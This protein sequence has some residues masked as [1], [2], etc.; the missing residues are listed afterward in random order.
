MHVHV[1]GRSGAG[2]G[3]VSGRSIPT[4]DYPEGVN[5]S[6]QMYLRLYRGSN[7][8]WEL[9]PLSSVRCI[10]GG[11]SAACKSGT[12]SHCDL[13]RPIWLSPHMFSV[14]TSAMDSVEAAFACLWLLEPA[15]R[16]GIRMRVGGDRGRG[17]CRIASG[18]LLEPNWLSMVAVHE[19][20]GGAASMARHV[21]LCATHL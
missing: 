19:C 9:L 4:C 10:W 14:A 11:R 20:R 6:M 13:L 15:Y 21:I 16:A 18:C 3:P 1:A 12:P 5:P 2:Q 8:F 7:P 17:S